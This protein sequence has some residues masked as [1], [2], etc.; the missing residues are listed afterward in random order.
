MRSVRESAVESTFADAGS[1]RIASHRV[2]TRRAGA[3]FHYISLPMPITGEGGGTEI[4]L[5]TD[6]VSIAVTVPSGKKRDKK[7]DEV[8]EESFDLRDSSLKFT[9]ESLLCDA[10]F[11]FAMLNI[12]IAESKKFF[13]KRNMREIVGKLFYL[14]H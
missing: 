5:I 11:S 13:F 12:S 6:R 3:L 9:R 7:K 1:R 2:A 14:W 8:L 4:N 10:I